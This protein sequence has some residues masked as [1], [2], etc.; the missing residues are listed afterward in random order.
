MST[1]R[2]F[3]LSLAVAAGASLAASAA[4][5][6]APRT[7]TRTVVGNLNGYYQVDG[8]NQLCSRTEV[9]CSAEQK[10]CKD[11]V[12]VNAQS[13]KDV[14]WTWDRRAKS[15]K[16]TR[17]VV[18]GP[19][20]PSVSID[21]CVPSLYE[22]FGHDDDIPDSAFRYQGPNG[23]TVSYNASLRLPSTSGFTL[24]TLNRIN[25]DFKGA[26]G[27]KEQQKVCESYYDAETRTC[28]TYRGFVRTKSQ[29]VSGQLSGTMSSELFV[30]PKCPE[31]WRTGCKP[32]RF[33]FPYNADPSRATQNSSNISEGRTT[34]FVEDV[35]KN[36][37]CSCPIVPLY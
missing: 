6:Q 8:S 32:Q 35:K 16:V 25:V 22:S 21:A 5:A 18:R 10:K 34:M 28:L 33:T 20:L 17:E 30:D 14:T 36:G 13:V 15:V 7:V 9:R 12:I 2:T 23:A 3:L 26:G 4:L 29:Q 1:S 19:A 11:T 37:T 27:E 31:P 24:I